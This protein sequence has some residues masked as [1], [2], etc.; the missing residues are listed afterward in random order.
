VPNKEE[1]DLEAWQRLTALEE[2]LRRREDRAAGGAEERLRAVKEEYGA[3]GLEEGDAR[4]ARLRKKA[5]K[6]RAAWQEA[7][8]AWLEEH[9]PG[10]DSIR[11]E[12]RQ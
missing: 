11:P 6:A 5:E 7:E 8:W 1:T 9:G 3:D 2:S 4:L 12:G 10:L